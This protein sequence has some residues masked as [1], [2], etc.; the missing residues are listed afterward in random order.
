M[1]TYWDEFAEK[2]G[3]K[4]LGKSLNQILEVEDMVSLV[5]GEGNFIYYSN[6]F[7]AQLPQFIELV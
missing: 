4:C 7:P 5:K 1:K 6:Q 3:D 2:C